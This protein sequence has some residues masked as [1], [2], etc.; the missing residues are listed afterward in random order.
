MV[1]QR[2]F[3]LFTIL[4]IAFAQSAWAVPLWS[5][6][7]SVPCSTCHAYPSLQLT[8]VGLDFFRKGHRFDKDTTDKD[9]SHL[10]SSHIEWEYAVQ[11]GQS[12]PFTAPVFHFHAGGALSEY[13]SVYADAG[14]NRDLETVYLQT[15]KLVTDH[16]FV[17]ARAG[18]ISPVIL[19]TYANGLM[20][21]A[22]APLIMSETTL[23]DNPFTPT[24]DDYGVSV[25]G[26]WRSL[27]FESGVINGP[28]APGQAAVNRHKDLF[29]SGEL[30]AK[31]GLSGVGLYYHRGGYDLTSSSDTFLFDRY[32][33]AAIFAN[34]TR[35]KFRLAG[36]YLRGK[37]SQEGVRPRPDINGY[38]AQLDFH[39]H[40]LAVPFVRYDYAKTTGVS[41]ADR[42]RK[43]TVGVAF[44]A[45]ETEASAGRIVVEG[46]RT[47]D[48]TGSS[49]S[50]LL[51]LLWAF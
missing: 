24:R 9:L 14:I 25:A 10:L 44:S 35:D 48:G 28:D 38:Y 51:N 37:D 40:P 47:H 29:A 11:K 16:S 5:R 42:T 50:A 2:R 32:D 23:G 20:A 19:R 3:V 43:A 22:S 15:T 17:T 18:K 30:A 33:R 39:P 8:T 49:N 4:I 41:T 27:F 36:A 6:R 7:Y 31:D 45:F 12:S 46:A 1:V 13:F 21:S 26:G 34:F